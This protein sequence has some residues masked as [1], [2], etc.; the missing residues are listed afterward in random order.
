MLGLSVSVEAAGGNEAQA[1]VLDAITKSMMAQAEK[2]VSDAKNGLL[3]FFSPIVFILLFGLLGL[4]RFGRGKAVGALIFSLIGL[5]GWSILNAATNEAAQAGIG[6]T[7]L[8]LACLLGAIG[9]LIGA[10]KPEAK[11]DAAPAAPAAEGDA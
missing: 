7:F 3:V 9:G 4:K 11:A 8:M 6:L 1:E 5:G 2:Q 10:I